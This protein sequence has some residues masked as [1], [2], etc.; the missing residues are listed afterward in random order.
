MVENDHKFYNK[1]IFAWNS[2][3]AAN[4]M[5]DWAR[6]RGNITHWQPN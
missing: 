6:K 5:T 4:K 2:I 3:S 1:T